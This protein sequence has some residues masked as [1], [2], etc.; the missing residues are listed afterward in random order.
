[1]QFKLKGKL[2][3]LVAIK[4]WHKILDVLIDAIIYTCFILYRVYCII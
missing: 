3:A 4:V 2:F 1:M